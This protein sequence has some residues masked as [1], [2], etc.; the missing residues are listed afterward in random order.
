MVSSTDSVKPPVRKKNPELTTLT[1][2]YSYYLLK[3]NSSFCHE[4]NFKG[5]KTAIGNFVQSQH[6]RDKMIAEKEKLNRDR[7]ISFIKFDCIL[8]CV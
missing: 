4:S 3:L 7:L 2:L 1:T 5:S 6:N 8:T